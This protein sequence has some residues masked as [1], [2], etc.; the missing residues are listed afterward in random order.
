M[1]RCRRVRPS[2][3]VVPSARHRSAQ[4]KP[5]CRASEHTPGQH[6]S[7]R[8]WTHV[9]SAS[10]P[11]QRAL[12]AHRPQ[13]Q[14]DRF[15]DIAHERPARFGHRRNVSTVPK[16]HTHTH[17]HHSL[18]PSYTYTDQRT[19]DGDAADRAAAGGGRPPGLL[20]L[21]LRRAVHRKGVSGRPGPPVHDHRLVCVTDGRMTSKRPHTP[22]G[23][24]AGLTQSPPGLHSTHRP[25]VGADN[26][27]RVPLHAGV[28]QA[29][30]LGPRAE[31]QRVFHLPNL[32]S[33]YGRG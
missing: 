33:T 30:P 6:P 11:I 26:A 25:P 24:G 18:V 8:A 29:D 5:K 20:R 9:R 21:G 4:K 15:P 2:C 7:T 16:N 27:G 19:D 3:A 10:D 17:S 13:N 14:V 12:R 23:N 32:T 28:P 31:V 22:K 1:G